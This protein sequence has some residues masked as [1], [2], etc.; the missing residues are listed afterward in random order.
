MNGRQGI[1][2]CLPEFYYSGAQGNQLT[3]EVNINVLKT[4][5]SEANCSNTATQTKMKKVLPNPKRDFY[6]PIMLTAMA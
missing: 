1:K 5:S 3:S 4:L 2:L 6:L